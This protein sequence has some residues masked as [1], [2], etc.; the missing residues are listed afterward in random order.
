[1]LDKIE[2]LFIRMM[3]SLRLFYYSLRLRNIMPF[4]GSRA[5]GP[6]CPHDIRIPLEQVNALSPREV[7]MLVDALV[8]TM[9]PF[10]VNITECRRCY[11]MTATKIRKT[12]IGL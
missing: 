6:S 1:M 2:L 11:C 7:A 9:R 8:D 12:V 5:V 4:T 3:L 10:G